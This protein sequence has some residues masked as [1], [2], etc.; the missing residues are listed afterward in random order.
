MPSSGP[1]TS[2]TCS[3]RELDLT[4]LRTADYVG[5]MQIRNTSCVTSGRTR[6]LPFVRNVKALRHEQP[7]SHRGLQIHET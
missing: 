4:P 1:V 2:H 6:T 5:V 7:N 3:Q